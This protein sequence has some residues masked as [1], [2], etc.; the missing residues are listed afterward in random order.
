MQQSELRQALVAARAE[1]SELAKLSSQ[2]L[3]KQQ[4]RMDELEAALAAATAVQA[5]APATQTAE[6]LA[7]LREEMVPMVAAALDQRLEEQYSPAVEPQLS[8]HAEAS[9][10]PEGAEAALERYLPPAISA[11]LREERAKEARANGEWAKTERGAALGGAS[12]ASPVAASGPNGPA[13]PARGGAAA[14]RRG[15]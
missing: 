15:S 3:A 4:H 11:A 9:F 12:T 1:L 8:Q 2:L 14:R 5:Q 13:A 6:L 7:S 10:P